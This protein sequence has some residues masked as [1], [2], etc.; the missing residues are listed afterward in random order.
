M[1]TG[2]SSASLRVAA[3]LE[4]L[5]AIR[6]F[7]EEAATALGIDLATV[8]DT[9]LAVDEAASNIVVHGY[10]DQPGPIEVKVKRGRDTLVIC[11][12]DEASPFDPTSI[13]AP[14]LTVPL[15][16]RATGGMGIHLI[17][18]IM[19]KVTHRVTSQG[20]NE[21]LLMKRLEENSEDF[22]ICD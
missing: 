19:D 21:L 8:T 1:K 5:A 2:I 6:R 12:R 10:R 7:V 17:R 15:E 22:D 4:N 18:Q 14:D 11:L 13:P 9:V 20:G 16:Q 3:K